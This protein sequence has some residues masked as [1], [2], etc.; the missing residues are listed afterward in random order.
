MAKI[1][2]LVKAQ[3]GMS[4]MVIINPAITFFIFYAF[5]LSIITLVFSKVA[6]QCDG[7]EF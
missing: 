4:N 1:R 5:R 7:M 6:G 3:V 2:S